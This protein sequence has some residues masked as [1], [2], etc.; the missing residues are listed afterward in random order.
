[1]NRSERFSWTRNGCL[2]KMFR[3][4]ER[5]EQLGVFFTRKMANRSAVPNCSAPFR[6]GFC[7]YRSARSP[8]YKAGSGTVAGTVVRSS[9]E[10]I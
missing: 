3:V 2:S 8:A 10:T 5:S 4:L 7:N 6:N 9:L 1:M